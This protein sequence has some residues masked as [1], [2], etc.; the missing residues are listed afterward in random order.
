[1][2]SK[3]LTMWI[4]FI[5]VL[6][7]SIFSSGQVVS[8]MLKPWHDVNDNFYSVSSC[9]KHLYSFG[10]LEVP[11]CVWCCDA[12][13][14]SQCIE[15]DVISNSSS[16]C[17]PD[18]LLLL[19]GKTC[20]DLCYASGPKCTSCEKKKW[21]YFCLSS[22]T[23]Q[24]PEDSCSEN[25]IVQQCDSGDPD[26]DQLDEERFY[27]IVIIC[28]AV[29]LI[30]VSI[31]GIASALIYRKLMQR[32]RDRGIAE[33]QQR[34]R[35][36]RTNAA[37]LAQEA[38]GYG[39][40]SLMEERERLL[41]NDSEFHQRQAFEA[42]EDNMSNNALSCTSSMLGDEPVC[43]LCLS[44]RPSV[45]F[46]PCY[47]TCCCEVCSNRLRPVSNTIVCPFCREEIKSMVSLT[48]VLKWCT[49]SESA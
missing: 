16:V 44:A 39:V 30:L 17:S 21:C 19:P 29:G 32:R 26:S 46:L 41:P 15:K 9:R 42:G 8:P 43:Y 35:L 40:H 18:A 4:C 31:L 10:C 38:S 36:Q 45:T 20:S 22:S 3:R 1:M 27:A 13:F 33:Q 28:I 5:F 34:R 25:A 47:H 48:N 2:L 6:Y 11:E 12:P 49:K 14:G 37:I 24:A 7:F 23:C